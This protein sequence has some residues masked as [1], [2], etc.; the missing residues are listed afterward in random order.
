M[1]PVASRLQPS[2]GVTP[3]S[4]AIQRT[5]K[6]TEMVRPEDGGP[7]GRKGR[8]MK[9]L[10]SWLFPVALF[11]GALVAGAL[12]NPSWSHA[13]IMTAA[14]QSSMADSTVG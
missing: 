6:K 12:K 14:L 2:S 5:P 13:A 7:E 4:A 11:G 10:L 8:G 1:G 9:K 3:R